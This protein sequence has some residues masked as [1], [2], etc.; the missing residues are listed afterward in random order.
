MAVA[1]ADLWS[2]AMGRPQVDPHDLAAAVQEQANREPLDY[3]TRLLIRDSIRALQRYWGEERT[4]VWLT[5]STARRKLEAICAEP[6]E[7]PGF[8]SLEERLMDKTDPEDIRQF[9]RD[10][11]VRVQRPLRLYV[12]G[13]AALILPGLLSRNTSDIDVVDEVPSELRSQHQLLAQLKKRYGLELAHFQSHYLPSGWDQRLHSIEPFGR[14]QVYLVDAYDVFLSKLFSI[15]EKDLDDMRVLAKQLDKA[16]LARRLL[17][18][19]QSALAAPDLRQR[20]VDNWYIL[21]G[22]ALPS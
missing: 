8:S 20:A 14:I 7:K 10:L 16:I 21:Y 17:D 9:F 11:S 13:S 3:R 12:G 1:G 2:L 19:T 4:A 5:R 15:R 22:E 6:F 18:T